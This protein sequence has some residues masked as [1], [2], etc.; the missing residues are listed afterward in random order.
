MLNNA[1]IMKIKF[2]KIIIKSPHVIRCF[3]FVADIFEGVFCVDNGFTELCRLIFGADRKLA[4][5]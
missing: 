4:A 2:K 1:A 5:K 3:C